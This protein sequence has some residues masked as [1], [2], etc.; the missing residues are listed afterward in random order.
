MNIIGSVSSILALAAVLGACSFSPCP[1]GQEVCG[2][3]CMI[4]GA[5]CCPGGNTNCPAGSVCSADGL[6][7]L[8]TTLNGCLSL[9]VTA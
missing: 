3:G 2:S 6:S 4:Q 1:E 5:S 8:N 9:G 7:C